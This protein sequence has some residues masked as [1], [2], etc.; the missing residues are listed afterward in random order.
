M[1]IDWYS[2][3]FAV[4]SNMA[5]NYEGRN[6]IFLLI[7]G[8]LLMLHTSNGYSTSTSFVFDS[9]DVVPQKDLVSVPGQRTPLRSQMWL[10][11]LSFHGLIIEVSASRW[12]R[13]AKNLIIIFCRVPCIRKS[14]HQY[15]LQFYIGVFQTFSEIL[16]NQ[17]TSLRF[18]VSPLKYPYCAHYPVVP[19]AF[20]SA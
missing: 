11:N 18:F 8:P 16:R 4:S 20:I 13:A 12:T 1:L 9:L 17:S 7:E 19:V 15:F 5:D 10:A 6:V 14:G 3:H 2:W